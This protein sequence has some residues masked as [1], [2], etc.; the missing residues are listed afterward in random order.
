M[1]KLNNHLL[2]KLSYFKYQ[3]KED[4]YFNTI[5]FLTNLFKF[6]T[7]DGTLFANYIASLLPVVQRHTQYLLFIKRILQFL[8]KV[9]SF[10]GVKVLFSGKLN[11]FTRAQSKQIQVGRVSLQSFNLSYISACAPAYTT[12]GKIG[13]KI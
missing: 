13:V 11:G 2:T 5:L 6:K 8:N 4:I 10:N 9:Y 1:L 3:F 7:P 12:A